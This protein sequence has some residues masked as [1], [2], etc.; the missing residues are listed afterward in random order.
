MLRERDYVGPAVL[1]RPPVAPDR[2]SPDYIRWVQRSLNRLI[3]SRLA[4][5]G[6]IGRQTRDAVRAFQGRRGLPADGVV[7][8]ATERALIAAGAG[9]PPGGGSGPAS[10]PATAGAA[11]TIT[12]PSLQA[13]R[14]NIVRLAN[15]EWRR[16]GQ[17]RTKEGSPQIRPVLEDYWA[18]GTGTQWREA[19]WWSAHPWSAA[20]ISWVMRQAGA[21][22]AFRYARAHSRYIKAAKDN[23]L[24]GN[25]NPFKAYRVNEVQPRP[26]DL[27]CKS[28]AGSGATYDN[29]REGMLTHC[30]IVTEVQP[31]RLLTI[32]GNVNN[33]VDRRAV[34]TDAAGHI[35]Q[36]GYFT[37]IRVG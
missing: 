6:V 7:G 18:T 23:R 37:V 24:A 19:N 28:R 36:P 4:V 2:R 3:G 8:P 16:W 34:R 17:G 31:G 9:Q 30:D 14:D 15:Q 10:R 13:L 35:A 29:I 33:S 22:T 1:E 26:G 27:V 25:S 11:G 5:D 12:A 21:G 32:G 20:F